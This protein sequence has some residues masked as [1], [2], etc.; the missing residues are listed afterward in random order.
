[1]RILSQY[2]N[3]T[4][5][6]RFGSTVQVLH[7][8][9]KLKLQNLDKESFAKLIQQPFSPQLLQELSNN[10]QSALKQLSNTIITQLKP[11]NVIL[12]SDD[13][14]IFSQTVLHKLNNVSKSG[15]YPSSKQSYKEWLTGRIVRYLE[16]LEFKQTVQSIYD[17]QSRDKHEILFARLFKKLDPYIKTGQIHV[18]KD[19]EKTLHQQIRVKVY[20]GILKQHFKTED[21][22]ALFTSWVYGITRNTCIDSIRNKKY[23]PSHVNLDQYVEIK[24]GDLLKSNNILDNTEIIYDLLYNNKSAIFK[25]L[26]EQYP[27]INTN[28]SP[29]WFKILKLKYPQGE[30]GVISNAV[31]HE[32]YGLTITNISTLLNRA[33]NRLREVMGIPNPKSQTTKKSGKNIRDS[34][35]VQNPRYDIFENIYTTHSINNNGHPASYYN[36]KDNWPSGGKPITKDEYSLFL[37]KYQ[38]EQI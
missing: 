26:I 35:I 14:G 31:I 5:S 13:Y 2:L 27:D 11:D 23:M 28:K 18:L 25:K 19:Y 24:W 34:Q 36:I 38:E 33:Y 8:Q 3:T 4:N 20:I 7:P 10:Y 9:I 12:K 21:N 32:R 30:Y 17:N 22:K 15:F 6:R 29:Q 16:D 37:N 1:M